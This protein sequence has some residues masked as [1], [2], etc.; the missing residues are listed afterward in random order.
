[1]AG[2]KRQNKRNG[3]VSKPQA[4]PKKVTEKQ[5]DLISKLPDDILLHILSMCPYHDAVR[6]AA[7][8]RR[9]QHLHTRLPNVR[10]RMSVLGNL[11]S[12]G[13]SSE[14]RV[15]SMERMLRQ[16]CHDDGGLHDT[17]ETLHI[18]YRKD[19]PFE[20]RYANEFVALA[21]ASR[22][23]LHVQCKRGLP[24]EDA[25]VWSLELPPATTELE[26]GLYWYAV[27]PPR[28]RGPGVTSLRWLALDGLTVLRPS[29][30]LS[31]VVFP[32]LEGAEHRRLHAPG[33]HR[34]HVRHHAAAQ[35]PPHH[36]RHLM[37]AT[38]KAGIAV[39][40]DELREI[41][42][43]CRCPTEPMSSSSPAAYHLLPRFRALFTRYSSCARP[44]CACSSGDA[45]S[46]TSRPAG[47]LFRENAS[48][49]M[50]G[51]LALRSQVLQT[52]ACYG[53]QDN[54]RMIAAASDGLWAG[55]KICGTMFTVRCVGQP[56]PCPT[57]AAAAPSPSRSST[58]APAAP[59]PSTS[60]G[61]PSP[62]SPTPSPA[63]SSS[64][65]NSVVFAILQALDEEMII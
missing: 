19:V 46:P 63:R 32:S 48:S 42:V 21:N 34:H 7:V 3:K 13:E 29:D 41:R 31:T 56:T 39:L 64:T 23:E 8:S 27:R 16:R 12:L 59:L 37:S 11:A 2:K 52:S 18:G 15:Q 24:D 22:L 51:G 50:K 9:W 17:I 44:S 38:T 43:S 65:T 61:R 49:E 60:P 57:R 14:P 33:Q 4:E 30:F 53:N 6:T 10:F 36:R 35:A 54:G 25:G 5:E 40:A 20:C 47:V 58:A 28:V 55:G 1:M 26:L 45:A 62:P